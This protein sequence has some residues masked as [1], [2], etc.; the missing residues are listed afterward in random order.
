[1]Y[2]FGPYSGAVVET[3]EMCPKWFDSKDIPYESMW[4]DDH[5]WLPRV[6]NGEVVEFDFTFDANGE[7]LDFMDHSGSF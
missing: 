3:E 7:V 4:S 6:L 2:R 5:Y 1:M